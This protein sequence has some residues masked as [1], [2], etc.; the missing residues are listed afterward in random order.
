MVV[1]VTVC[2]CSFVSNL[3]NAFGVSWLF[4]CCVIKSES[5][6]KK[7]EDESTSWFKPGLTT[8]S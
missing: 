7:E 2:L 4:L 3:V 1:P 8:F 5:A 6:L